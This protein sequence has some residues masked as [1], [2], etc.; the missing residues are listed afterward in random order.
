MRPNAPPLNVTGGPPEHGMG[1]LKPQEELLK[2]ENQPQ[3]C[4]DKQG[5]SAAEF[6]FYVQAVCD[7]L[8][9]YV[10]PTA[11]TEILL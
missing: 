10:W 6:L 4:F 5:R 3:L 8:L 1:T 2:G 11:A 9:Y 7:F